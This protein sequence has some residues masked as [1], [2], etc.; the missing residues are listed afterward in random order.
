MSTVSIAASTKP[1]TTTMTTSPRTKGPA[2]T[3]DYDYDYSDTGTPVYQEKLKDW[4]KYEFPTRSPVTDFDPL[5]V[6]IYED[7]EEA[8]NQIA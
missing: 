2:G 1:P 3:T 8:T 5:P 6:D 7:E 4:T